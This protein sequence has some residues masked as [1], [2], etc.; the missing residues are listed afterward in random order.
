MINKDKLFQTLDF[1]DSCV[2]SDNDGHSVH[3]LF[4][5]LDK[6]I[7]IKSAILAID[8]HEQFQLTSPSQLFTYNLNS[9]WQQLHFQRKFYQQDPVLNAASHSSR[10][11]DWQSAFQFS[12][13][14]QPYSSDFQLL[15]QKYVG[16]HGLSV[17]VNNHSGS[18]LLSLATQAMPDQDGEQLL[19]Y[20]APHFHELFSRDGENTRRKMGMPQL[21]ARELEVLKWAKE[22]KANGDIAQ[23]LSISERTIKFHLSN[24]FTKFNVI[25]RTQAIAKAMHFGIIQ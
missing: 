6:I 22:G 13:A 23:I 16:S 21:S 5:K 7:P 8:I 1:I 11:I 15:S 20:I 24:I 18:T 14:K 25:N 17:V 9:E 2:K 10:V 4:N 12:P 3:L 19:S